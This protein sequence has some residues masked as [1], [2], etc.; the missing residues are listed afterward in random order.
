MTV[1][2]CKHS[3]QFSS[4]AQLCPTL[5]RR[6]SLNGILHILGVGTRNRLGVGGGNEHQAHPFLKSDWVRPWSYT[7]RALG[8]AFRHWNP[9]K[10][11][12]PLR[13][14]FWWLEGH[15]ALR[16]QGSSCWKGRDFPSPESPEG[17]ETLQNF[18]FTNSLFGSPCKGFSIPGNIFWARWI[19]PRYQMTTVKKRQVLSRKNSL[20][21]SFQ[22]SD[23]GDWSLQTICLFYK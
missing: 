5:S 16:S 22:R 2:F 21:S 10:P 9:W 23:S 6:K 18:P 12:L 15:W 11:P 8:W 4:V 3:V 7:T 20:I 1:C 13:P 17:K 19:L 14:C